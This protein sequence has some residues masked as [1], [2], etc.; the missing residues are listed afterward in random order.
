[1]GRPRL[2]PPT[3][4]D[5]VA[6]PTPDEY[7]FIYT[8]GDVAMYVIDHGCVL[9]RKKARIGKGYLTSKGRWGL[10]CHRHKHPRLAVVADTPQ[11]AIELFEREYG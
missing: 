1:M 4:E 9:W 11:K 8:C 10:F 6:P 5:K 3:D 2:T 7:D